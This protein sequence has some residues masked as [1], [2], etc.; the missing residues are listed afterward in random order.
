MKLPADFSRFLPVEGSLNLRDF[1]GYRTTDGRLVRSGMLLRSGSLSMIGGA[2]LQDFEGLDVG[3]ICDLRRLDEAERGPAPKHPAFACRVHIPIAPG[4]NVVLR[5][6][7]EDRSQSALDR[8]VIMTQMMRDLV[9]DHGDD[10]GA[11][12]EALLSCERGFLVH[13][14]AGKDRT[15]FAALLIL[16][17]LGVD[18]DTIRSDYLLTNE[19]ESLRRLMFGRMRDNHRG[20]DDESLAAV[21]GVKEEYLDAGMHEIQRRHGSIDA[22]LSAIG[23]GE[24][25]RDALRDRLLS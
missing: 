21:A 10:Y 3:V 11:M 17:A 15:G 16:A 22:Y 1:G 18:E 4:S 25:E 14:S 7:L 13:C 24:R 19:A 2:G 5:E 6:S 23:V 8:I 12:F 20:I 9:S